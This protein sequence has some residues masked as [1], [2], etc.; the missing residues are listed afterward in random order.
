VFYGT[1]TTKVPEDT[2]PNFPE[3][4]TPVDDD[5]PSFPEDGTPDIKVKA[6]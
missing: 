2:V 5:A 3:D 1:G 6:G 4:G